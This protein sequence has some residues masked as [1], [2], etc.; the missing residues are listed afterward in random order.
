MLLLII[1]ISGAAV[2]LVMVLAHYN[3]WKRYDAENHTA[4]RF[5]EGVCSDCAIFKVPK[6]L[7]RILLKFE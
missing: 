3:G 2:W 5:N 6:W 1:A 4:F 7:Q